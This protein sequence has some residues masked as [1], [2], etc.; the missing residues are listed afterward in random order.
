MQQA[1]MLFIIILGISALMSVFLAAWARLHI[2]VS[3]AGFFFPLML[4]ISIYT[5]GYALELS[6]VELHRVLAAIRLEYVGLSFL[7]ALLFLFTLSFIR[8]TPPP[9]RLVRMALVFPAVTLILVL[10]MNHH[11]LYYINPRM[12]ESSNY[13]VLEF[14]RGLW[15]LINYAFAMLASTSSVLMLAV[16]TF[17]SRGKVKKQALTITIGTSVPLLTSIIY[18][19]A[20]TPGIPDPVPMALT[21]SGIILWFALFKLG[22]FELVPAA[23]EQ[24][25]DSIHE[26]FLVIDRSGR[27]QD[28]NQAALQIPGASS[29]VIGDSLPINN[30]LVESLSPLLNNEKDRINF[31]SG[32]R[33][34]NARS[35]TI[36]HNPPLVE[37]SAILIHDITENVELVERLNQKANTDELTG[38]LNRRELFNAGE[39]AL[40]RCRAARIPLGL[41]MID[42]D[43]FKQINDTY[44][45][46]AGDDALKHVANMLKQGLRESDILGRYGGEEF[47]IF[48]PGTD[49]SRTLH[50][51]ER[52]RRRIAEKAFLAKGNQV[53]L[54]AS[55]GV[56]SETPGEDTS[57]DSLLNAADAALYKAKGRGRNQVVVL[58]EEE[59]QR[60]AEQGSAG[61]HGEEQPG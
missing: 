59:V 53:K 38:L 7:P 60:H 37:G 16:H 48:L 23:R 11:N 13:V 6:Q 8:G 52:L 3:G 25:L 46:A 40:L 26:A 57:I 61:R 19:L 30:P 35:Y 45:H 42:L 54:S 18:F 39:Q 49:L 24:A 31:S 44:G 2:R 51:A 47:V 58:P 28:L 32:S 41:I 17:R 21:V 43:Y 12:A 20:F 50:T 9:E 27:L 36:M 33:V 15:Y 10:T 22:L 1:P 29:L 14:E 34:F 55:S 56:Y 5:L 4:S